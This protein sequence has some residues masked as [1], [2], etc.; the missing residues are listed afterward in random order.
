MEVDKICLL[1]LEWEESWVQL[2]PR[3][4]SYVSFLLYCFHRKKKWKEKIKAKVP[5]NTENNVHTI[6]HH[7]FYFQSRSSAHR[8]AT[9]YV[10]VQ[11]NRKELNNSNSFCSE[12]HLC[13]CSPSAL[14]MPISP[15][16][17]SF[18]YFSICCLVHV[19]SSVALSSDLFLVTI[20]YWIFMICQI[21]VR[22]A[23]V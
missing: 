16:G 20:T 10:I 21:A 3:S 9:S 6:K 5:N 7:E 19:M 1:L 11:D 14:T 13:T 8:P 18:S 12:M 22:T 4:V 23:A 2:Q 17:K 15:G